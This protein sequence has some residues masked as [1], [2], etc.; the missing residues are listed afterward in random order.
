MTDLS[1]L[2]PPPAEWARRTDPARDITEAL[3]DPVWRLANIY[4]IYDK[5]RKRFRPF[6]P[7]PEQ[8][9]I[10]WDLFVRGI[11][12][13]IIPKAR[14]IGFSTLLAIVALDIVLWQ[15]GAKAALVDKTKDDGMNKMTDIVRVAWDRLPEDLRETFGT[16]V[17]NQTEFAARV[18]GVP[19]DGWSRFRVH[20]SGRGDALVFLWVS[21]WGTIQFE[22]PKRSLEIRTGGMAAAE[23]GIRVIETTWKGGEGGDVWPY[24]EM[25]LSLP[26]DQKDPEIDWYIR[27]FPW[28]VEPSYSLTTTGHIRP[29]IA[30]YLD[31]KE[32]EISAGLGR[33][34]TFTAGQRAWYDRREQEFGLFVKREYPTTLE[35]CWEAP[36][37]GAIYADLYA[38][39][40]ADGRV[41]P[42]AYFPG[43]P[44]YTLWDLGSPENTVVWYFQL[45]G[46]RVRFIDCDM[47]LWM[48]TAERVAHMKAKGYTFAKHFLP[49]DANQ[50]KTSVLTFRGELITAGLEGTQVVP[51]T[52]DIELGIN[53]TRMLFPG[54]EFDSLKCA[55]GA[56]CIK[57]YHRHP[58]RHTPVPD[59]NEHACDALKVLAEAE[60]NGM[61]ALNLNTTMPNEH[62][63]FYDPD[64]LATLRQQ[65]T[66]HESQ[67]THGTLDNATF[68][69]TDPDDAWLRLYEPPVFGRRYHITLV[70]HK[71]ERE[72]DVVACWR[73]EGP[74]LRLVA[75]LAEDLTADVP[76]LARW[77]TALS[78]HYG[79]ATVV[80]VVDDTSGLL[81]ALVAEGCPALFARE[82]A[83]EARR[84]GQGKR[85][86]KRGYELTEPAR[87]QAIMLLQDAIRE[88]TLFAPCDELVEQC[89]NFIQVTPDQPPKAAPGHGE[90]WVLA[91]G[92]AF[93]TRAA[94]VVLQP[95]RQ[96]S[97]Y[98]RGRIGGAVIAPA[99]FAGD[100][101]S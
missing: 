98:G 87:E 81:E 52:P 6:T 69:R 31:E 97:G 7:K 43:V 94:G 51:V 42:N 35:E 15:A 68:L 63:R 75:C 28:F 3:H 96:E 78:V 67:V 38:Q 50:M 90:A 53:R 92:I 20:K 76:V 48:T 56:K 70:R 77:T 71:H 9:I 36:V 64:G 88:E 44:V 14:Q 47:K 86:R 101:D 57:A 24:I 65:V 1:S 73:E 41:F 85:L 46:G 80:P 29:S 21:E 83:R 4:T 16:P 18:E 74:G 95:L 59:H 23:G 27:F 37:E 72:G 82:Q 30:A 45:V 99:G 19:E 79:G 25:A 22:E 40:L 2:L 58:E 8:Q 84:V 13:L 33:S 12:N 11:K 62:L 39:A 89:A 5:K 34:F 91:A 55:D 61:I 10:I 60:G 17:L 66:T 93:H 49:H 54:F 32:K 26:D 100:A